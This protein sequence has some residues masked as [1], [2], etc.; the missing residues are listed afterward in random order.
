ML[1]QNVSKVEFSNCVALA[2][3]CEVHG[4]ALVCCTHT[5]RGQEA[6][7]QAID[8]RPPLTS[9]VDA[10]S[11]VTVCSG[12]SIGFPPIQVVNGE[13]Q[14]ILTGTNQGYVS[15]DTD[16]DEDVAHVSG[17]FPYYPELYSSVR[18]ACVQSLSC[19]F[20]PGRE[21]PILFGD[22]TT[23]CALSYMFKVRDTQARGFQRWYTFL[24]ISKDRHFLVASWPF[25]VSKFRSLSG[26]LQTKAEAL[27][28]AERAALEGTEGF[29]HRQHS[30]GVS[31]PEHFLRRRGNQAL[32]S[33][34]ELV[35]LP[36]LSFRLHSVF[37]WS[38]QAF[39]RRVHE[40]H[41]EG[42]I[43]TGT[44]TEDLC[45][46][47][48]NSTNANETLTGS[49]NPNTQPSKYVDQYSQLETWFGV[50]NCTRLL[51]HVVVG[52]QIIVKSQSKDLV[53]SLLRYFKQ[54]IPSFCCSMMEYSMEYVEPFHC[55]LLGMAPGSLIPLESD[56]SHIVLLDI[57]DPLMPIEGPHMTLPY[58]IVFPEGGDDEGG[59]C[60][61]VR[62]LRKILKLHLSEDAL[63]LHLTFLRE[64]WL[65]KAKLFY[66]FVKSGG[67]ENHTRL[68]EFLRSIRAV[69]SDL[70]VLRFW[71]K[72]L[73]NDSRRKMLHE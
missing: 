8:E 27:F 14:A 36:D 47:D 41:A 29:L 40:L 55:N 60:T 17:R 12:C 19:E 23:G 6:G 26:E 28:A 33:L 4:P 46:P 45:D 7:K 11:S 18:Q 44:F 30:F 66:K 22:D 50:D 9:P 20:C 31:S 5:V 35:D 51:F 52:D 21:G 68:Q 3:F 73:G 43:M 63:K 71:T 42:R 24:F 67:A 69:E 1:P 64:S 56:L 2:V 10:E 65:N 61:L 58:N 32:R 54:F 16:A 62:E 25:L 57:H 37:S 38:L 15:W 72:G 70:P 13:T 34:S 59:R 53:A 39:A 48:N 49:T